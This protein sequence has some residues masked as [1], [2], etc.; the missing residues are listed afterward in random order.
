M[1]IVLINFTLASVILGILC[2][3]FIVWYKLSKYTAVI[4]Y[5]SA[6]AM[7]VFSTAFAATINSI[8]MLAPHQSAAVILPK[9]TIIQVQ[10]HVETQKTL[11]ESK[12]IQAKES[13]STRSTSTITAKNANTESPDLVLLSITYSPMRISYIMMWVATIMLLRNYSKRL[14]RL[15]FWIITVCYL[16]GNIYSDYIGLTNQTQKANLLYDTLFIVSSITAGGILFGSAFLTVANSIAGISNVNA[17]RNYLTATAYGIVLLAISLT[18][19]IVYMPYPPFA[20]TAWSFVA[21]ASYLFSLGFFSSAISI[22]H[23]SNLR[24]LL[25]TS[26]VEQQAKF[27]DNIGTAEMQKELEDRILDLTNKESVRMLEQTGIQPSLSE[28]DVKEYLGQVLNEMDIIKR[29]TK[30]DGT[31]T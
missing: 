21:L 31:M 13:P 3:K 16:S 29:R 2:Y 6:F 26:I 15:K 22:S 27:L 14:G 18:S 7:I 19:P 10:Q 23:D 1:I 12:S 5:G 4:L 25:R 11:S 30:S 28:D 8:V 24:K 20:A 17:V 9:K